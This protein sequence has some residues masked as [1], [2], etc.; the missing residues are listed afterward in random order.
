VGRC[1]QQFHEHFYSTSFCALSGLFFYECAFDSQ[2]LLRALTLFIFPEQNDLL[3][4]PLSVTR[5]HEF[6]SP[7]FSRWPGSL[8]SGP[9]AAFSEP[10]SALLFRFFPCRWHRRGFPFPFALHFFFFISPPKHQPV[11][12]SSL[13][14]ASPGF[15]PLEIVSNPFFGFWFSLAMLPDHPFSF[16]REGGRSASRSR[17]RS[18]GFNLTQCPD[19]RSS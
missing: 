5:P 7:R 16:L 14:S 15:F 10:D 12:D 2:L 9:Y 17:Q 19:R 13:S 11:F 3:G 4:L 1:P 18:L 8:H 6:I